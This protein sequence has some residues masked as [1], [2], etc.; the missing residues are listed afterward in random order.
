MLSAQQLFQYRPDLLCNGHCRQGIQPQW[1]RDPKILIKKW[2][3]DRYFWW[4]RLYRL[5]SKRL[6]H[7]RQ[8]ASSDCWFMIVLFTWIIIWVWILVVLF[9]S[10]NKIDFSSVR[11]LP[12]Y[13]EKF[14]WPS[15]S[16][17]SMKRMKTIF[18]N[19][20]YQPCFI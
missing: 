3:S 11:L 1:R 5:Q 4:K 2:I 9:F 20:S 19:W 14:F 16:F 13:V 18:Q 6:S 7:F 8:W 17:Q 10:S 15:W 12:L